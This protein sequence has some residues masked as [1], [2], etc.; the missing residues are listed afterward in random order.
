M[1]QDIIQIPGFLIADLY[2][3]SIVVVKGEPISEPVTQPIITHP[4]K[5]A[6]DR[7]WYLGSNLQKITIVVSEM[8]AVYLQDEALAFL[9]SILGACKLDLGDVAIVNHHSD[10]LEYTLL[11]KKLAPRNLFLFGVNATAL[12]LPFTVPNYQVQ[13]H[14]NCNFL[15]APALDAMLG[16]SQS[17]KLE[18][19]K[20]WLCL[21]KI[22]AV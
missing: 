6:T 14:D 9:S 20:L 5:N 17:A 15:L 11:K 8:Q 12:R 10:P 18:K 7:K 1:D 13:R 16:N 19:S 3:H 21:K 2:K 4:E 22:F